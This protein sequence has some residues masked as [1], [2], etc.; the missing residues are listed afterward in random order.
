MFVPI[1]SSHCSY[2][3]LIGAVHDNHNVL[4]IIPMFGLLGNS[5]CCL[6]VWP[7][8][9]Q[10]EYEQDAENIQCCRKEVL[11]MQYLCPALRQKNKGSSCCWVVGSPPSKTD[12]WQWIT[13]RGTQP[14][15]WLQRILTFSWI[16]FLVCP[17]L[18]LKGLACVPNRIWQKWWYLTPSLAH[19]G[20]LFHVEEL[21]VIEPGAHTHELSCL[22]SS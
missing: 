10:R 18:T 12:N 11:S 16:H 19:R 22:H 9:K 5:V 4:S 1:Q 14:P 7:W 6:D 8:V 20:T 2:F 15:R 21:L 17:F 3:L 13:Q